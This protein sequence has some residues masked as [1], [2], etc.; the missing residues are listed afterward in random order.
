MRSPAVCLLALSPLLAGCFS[1][2]RSKAIVIRPEPGAATVTVAAHAV[3]R[4]TDLILVTLCKLDLDLK[5]V[6]G[7]SASNPRA[8]KAREHITAN[9]PALREELKTG[10]GPVLDALLVLLAVPPEQ[11]VEAVLRLKDISI[12]MGDD[13]PAFAGLAV[14]LLLRD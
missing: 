14:D 6:G 9:Y 12:R 5:Q 4:C 11:R 1:V 10:S 7:R 8:G 3:A 13:P 2:R